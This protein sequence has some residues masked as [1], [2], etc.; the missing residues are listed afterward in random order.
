MGRN[1]CG[2]DDAARGHQSLSISGGRFLGNVGGLLNQTARSRALGRQ[3][4]ASAVQVR[5]RAVAVA[6]LQ[7][8]RGAGVPAVVFYAR[9][10]TFPLV[11]LAADT[12]CSLRVPTPNRFG[13]A[14]SPW[15]PGAWRFCLS[16]LSLTAS[17]TLHE[18]MDHD[19]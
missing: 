7:H 19:A 10:S 14:L 18:R 15:K 13:L 2:M 11:S 12:D 16:Q 3:T 8:A 1:V 5:S 17:R 4:T 6:V 9:A